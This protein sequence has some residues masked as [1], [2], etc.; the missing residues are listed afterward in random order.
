MKN[1]HLRTK[2]FIKKILAEKAS[3][4]I[5]ISETTKRDIIKYLGVDESK[6]K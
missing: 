2:L 4:I 1:L 5:A 3:K 6:L